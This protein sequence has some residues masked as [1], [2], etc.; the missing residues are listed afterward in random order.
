LVVVLLRV[1]LRLAALVLPALARSLAADLGLRPVAAE[2]RF[3]PAERFALLGLVVLPRLGAAAFLVVFLRLRGFSGLPVKA[4]VMAVA[5]LDTP[6]MAASMLV[7]A[8]SDMV[9]STPS[10]FSLSMLFPPF[11]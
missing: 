4:S 7:L 5:T 10:S 9:P 1:D 2:D 6:S 3:L 8:A 11:L